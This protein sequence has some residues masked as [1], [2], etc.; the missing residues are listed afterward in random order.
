MPLDDI[1][2]ILF[3]VYDTLIRRRKSDIDHVLELRSDISRPSPALVHEA[4]AA[5]MIYYRLERHQAWAI[6]DVHSFWTA[7]YAIYLHQ[8]GVPDPEGK[9]AE[10][11]AQWARSPSRYSITEG[12]FTI[13]DRLSN[14]GYRLGLL[15]N[16]DTSL[17]MFCRELGFSAHNLE[18]ILAS[19]EI[20]IRKPAAEIFLEGCRR[21]DVEPHRT[22]YVGDSYDKDVIGA[23]NAGLHAAWFNWRGQMPPRSEVQPRLIIRKLEELLAEST[24]DQNA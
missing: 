5:A 6:A 7:F 4:G 8:L 3:D 20:G 19:D 17:P 16:F 12:A 15:S 24:R 9:D 11:L 10:K 1:T 14:R 23:M 22:L 2:V 13:L 18:L 21:L